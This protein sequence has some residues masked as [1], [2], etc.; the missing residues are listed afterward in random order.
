MRG[1]VI[2]IICLMTCGCCAC[3][4]DTLLLMSLNNAQTGLNLQ[5]MERSHTEL[6]NELKNGGGK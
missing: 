5:G 6:M 1:I 2:L 4:K 3:K